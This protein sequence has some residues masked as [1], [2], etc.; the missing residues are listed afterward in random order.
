M[1]TQRLVV[2]GEPGAG[3]SVLALLLTLALLAQRESTQSTQP[4]PVLLTASSWDPHAEHLYVWM[5]RQ[6]EEE[7]RALRNRRLYGRHAALHLI[8]T[9]RV[10]PVIDGLDE[11]P[12][13]LHATAVD[14]INQAAG[15]GKPLVITCRG[16][17]Y[18]AAVS[19]SGAALTSAPVI[20][21]EP[22]GAEDAITFLS[23]GLVRTVTQWQP[24]FD[25]MRER[26]D[27][28]L[29]EAFSTPLM[30]S[31]ARAVF[32]DPAKN[33]TGLLDTER[34][35]TAAAI[36]HHLL[37]GYIP[38]LYTDSPT[39][40][41]TSDLGRYRPR[42]AQRWLTFVATHLA[43][44]KTRDFAWWQLPGTRTLTGIAFLSTM[45][46]WL[47]GHPAGSPFIWATCLGLFVER[48][49]TLVSSSRSRSWRAYVRQLPII[50]APL[51]LFGAT[52]TST[53]IG[54]FAGLVFGLT[55]ASLVSLPKPPHRIRF[56]TP[57]L[58][59]RLGVSLALGAG[60]G[61]AL[62]LVSLIPEGGADVLSGLFLGV[63]CGLATWLEG[64][65]DQL[66]SPSPRAALRSDATTVRLRLLALIGSYI[67][68]GLLT[69]FPGK[70]SFDFAAQFVVMHLGTGVGLVLKSAWVSSLL[71]RIWWALLG[72]L[73]WRL[74]RFL[75]D[76]H[77]RGVLR[78]A[79]AVYQ[80]RHMRL[81]DHLIATSD[82]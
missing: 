29:A 36:E 32:T 20:E 11:L 21:L 7:Y 40:P 35:P 55:L 81:Q 60:I 57:V 33:P 41:S 72:K 14:R 62:E 3:K 39:P 26:P 15:A 73:P 64:P 17:E 30:V 48:L 71:P 51:I 79:G 10:M 37:D 42:Q 63:P 1:P 22:V 31:L 8:T 53:R 19:D 5:A 50:L 54:L 27:G 69:M 43:R 34:F 65:P 6:L 75:E 70:V 82:T 28:V 12:P 4:V 67:L 47:L 23:S 49:T 52:L 76:A 77:R 74:M 66:R 13:S 16:T 24:V 45:C 25:V 38:A 80:F 56:R 46:L 18:E 59:R 68:L 61:F 44:Q 78:Q 58:L 9:G 2:L